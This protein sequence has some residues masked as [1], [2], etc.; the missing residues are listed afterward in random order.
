MG[1]DINGKGMIM[2]VKTQKLPVGGIDR[3]NCNV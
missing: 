3:R 2:K 1:T